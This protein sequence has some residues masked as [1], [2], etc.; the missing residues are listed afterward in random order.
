MIL[1]THHK[2]ARQYAYAAFEDAHVDVHR[3]A[4]YTLAFEKGGGERNDRRIGCF[5]KLSHIIVT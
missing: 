2:T 3:K 5:Q 4:V 1:V